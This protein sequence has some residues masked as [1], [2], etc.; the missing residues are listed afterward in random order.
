MRCCVTGCCWL[1]PSSAAVVKVGEQSL[2]CQSHLRALLFCKIVCFRAH[3]VKSACCVLPIMLVVGDNGGCFITSLRLACFAGDLFP[4]HGELCASV[5][6]DLFGLFGLRLCGNHCCCYIMCLCT[7]FRQWATQGKKKKKN[8]PT[9]T[10][11]GTTGLC[12]RQGECM[13][14]HSKAV[15]AGK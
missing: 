8:C 10:T 7:F 2:Q 3:L 1:S 9:H 14:T 13:R 12:P 11:Y 4:H 5:S 6:P 15:C